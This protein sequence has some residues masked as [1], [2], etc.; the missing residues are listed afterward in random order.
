[1]TSILQD[2][3]YAF[4]RLI[5]DRRFTLA[6]V[7]ALALG[8]GATSAV[9]TIV[10]AVLLRSLPFD[11]PDRVMWVGTRDGQS[12]EFGV[13]TPDYE[14]WRRATRTFSGISIIFPTPMNVSAD[15]RAPDRYDGVFISANGLALIGARAAIG[16][17][18][19][20]EDDRPGAPSVMLLSH[21]VWQSRYGGDQSVIGRTVRVNS[22]PSTIVG[23]MPPG[24]QFP[25]NTQVWLP[26][27]QMPAAQ[28]RGGRQGRMM[29]AYGRLADSMTI[30][31]A[32]TEMTGIAAQLAKDYPDSNKDM[33]ATVTP[34]SE[35]V[36]GTQIR[37][38][39]WSLMGA[40]AFVLLIACANVANLLLARASDRSRE[41][42]VRVSIG[43]TRWR[44]VKQLLVESVLLAF[45]AGVAGLGLAYFGVRWF[46]ANTQDIG[47]P[48][49]MVFTMDPTVFAFFA[50]VC[51]LTGIVFG[52][53]PAIYVS[54][55]SVSEVMKDGGRA[56]SAGFRA[57]RWTTGL[58][59]AELTLTVVLLS[60]AGLMM[61]SFLNLYRMDIGVDTSRLVAMQ[62]IFPSRSYATIESRALFLQRLDERLTGISTIEGASTTNYLPFQGASLRRLEIEG[63]PASTQPPVV[64]MVAIGTKYFDALGVRLLRGR[65]FAP[66]DGEPGREAMIINQRLAD[67]YFPGEDPIGRRIRLINDGN[68]PGAPKFYGATVVGVAPIIRQRGFERDPDPIVYITHAQNFGM[69]M[70]AAIIVRARSS[71]AAVTA[72]LRQEV[73]AMDPDVPVTNIRTM[74]EI[75]AR[76][77]WP[78][79][80][81]GTMFLAFAIIAMVLAAVGLYSVTSYS[82]SQRT[83]EIGIRM[84][85]G[86]EEKQ[87]RWLILRRGMVQLGIGLVLGLAG[88]VGTGRLLQGMLV[89]T[90]SAD[91]L[92]LISIS[93]VLI[94]VAVMACF[95]P[96]RRAMRLDPV[97]ALR[98]E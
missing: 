46:D 53:A 35:Q 69:Q 66:T 42:A 90:G 50:G 41:I 22:E 26:M 45:V 16:R 82:V 38:L 21:T 97:K 98:Y 7:A 92:T 31:Q 51:L 88:A 86:A 49:W 84:A 39:F 47:K 8:I 72:L 64:S 6:A 89:G 77:R 76:S 65:A 27:S 33:T 94:S 3:R 75:L 5:K 87:V 11:E 62:L 63:R 54:R 67:M 34:F 24:M 32:R 29:M 2:L 55:T 23:V 10:N 44:I 17:G 40:V 19:I 36:I 14:D 4:R 78:Q 74:D 58:I 68:M 18:F 70:A 60:G 79:R 15:D 30:E 25:F 96:A 93:V 80:T 1:M 61:R 37:V 20:E 81:F 56:G 95:W 85:L 57:R 83:Q 13:S 43:A 12:R 9:F 28:V 52:L 73:T 59:V 91:P 48:Y 71:P